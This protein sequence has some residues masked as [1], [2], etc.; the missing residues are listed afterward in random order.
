F[1]LMGLRHGVM[2]TAADDPD[3]PVILFTAL[4]V[5]GSLGIAAWCNYF[6]GSYF[7]QTYL[8]ILPPARLI[9]DGRVLLISKKWHVQPLWFDFKPQI[10]FACLTLALAILVLSAVATAVSTRLGQVM[11]VVV[12]SGV[13]VFGLLSNYFIGRRAFQNHTI[14]LVQ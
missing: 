14:G 12:C 8:Q 2:S 7:T 10:T 3:Q 9:A 5:F 6:Y 11:T 1:L 13:F 4:A